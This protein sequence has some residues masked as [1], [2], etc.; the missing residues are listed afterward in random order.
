MTEQMS[1]NE[2]KR[3]AI[4]GNIY[5][6]EMNIA[7][8]KYFKKLGHNFG[9]Y[10]WNFDIYEYGLGVLLVGYRVPSFAK[11]IEPKEVEKAAI[12]SLKEKIK[13]TELTKEK[14]IFELQ[15]LTNEKRKII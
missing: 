14:L 5:Y 10:G 8:L 1:K 3:L 4:N 6:T 2:V 7:A 9:E 15:E 11:Y 13:I 12:K